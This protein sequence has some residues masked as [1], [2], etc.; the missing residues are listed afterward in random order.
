MTGENTG[1]VDYLG[2][3]VDFFAGIREIVFDSS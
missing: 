1:S 2:S 3:I